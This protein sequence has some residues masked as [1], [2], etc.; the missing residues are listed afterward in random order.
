MRSKNRSQHNQQPGFRTPER[1]RLVTVPFAA[2]NLAAWL[3][4]CPP[5]A[6]RKRVIAQV[7]DNT[8]Q[9]RLICATRIT[10]DAFHSG[11]PT[12]QGASSSRKTM[13][14]P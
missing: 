1:L 13:P 4:G 14:I 12:R 9:K 6:G 10:S 3:S 7:R 11:I 8:N 5:I 2:D